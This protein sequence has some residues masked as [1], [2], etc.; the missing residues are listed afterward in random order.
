[1]PAE[2]EIPFYFSMK[3]F[4]S[5]KPVFLSKQLSSPR[6]GLAAM[7]RGAS[8]AGRR[9]GK[10]LA[11]VAVAPIP[12]VCRQ[13]NESPAGKFVFADKWEKNKRIYH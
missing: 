2:I 3:G 10:I 7:E 5:E 9:G 6:G 4:A 13:K 11:A 12:S 8:S 1:M